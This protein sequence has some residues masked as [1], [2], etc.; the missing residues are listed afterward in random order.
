[1]RCV[2]SYEPSSNRR[3]FFLFAIYDHLDEPVFHIRV[4][5]PIRFTPQGSP[6]LLMSV[7]D[8]QLAKQ[9]IAEGKLDEELNQSEFHR[10]ITQG[11]SREVC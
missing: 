6:L 8:H 2:K 3:S 9:L 11:V 7:I 5:P 1:M 4:Q 10:I